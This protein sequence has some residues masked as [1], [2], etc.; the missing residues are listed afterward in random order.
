ARLAMGRIA[1]PAA[2]V[3]SPSGRQKQ[4]VTGASVAHSQMLRMA[5]TLRAYAVQHEGAY[6]SDLGYLLGQGLL[7]TDTLPVTG[8]VWVY[9]GQRLR[10]PLSGNVIILAPS[11][12]CEGARTCLFGDGRIAR[13]PESDWS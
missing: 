4:Q 13:V 7:P 10:Q 3:R 8:G 5:T 9:H 6:P 2:A 12:P 11:M 1:A